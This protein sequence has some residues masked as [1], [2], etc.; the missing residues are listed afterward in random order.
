M[1]EKIIGKVNTYLKTY[2]E[3]LGQCKTMEDIKLFIESHD[4]LNLEDLE[5]NKKK[6]SKNHIKPEEQCQALRANKTQCTRRKKDN[7]AYCGTH[8][9]GTPYGIIE[10]NPLPTCKKTLQVFTQEMQGILYYI[11]NDGNIYNTE[12]IVNRVAKP[13]IVGKYNCTNDVYVRIKD[14]EPI[15]NTE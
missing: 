4:K 3:K 2:N 6:R 12:D 13:R 5:I 14:E 9:K 11:D 10:P 8:T 15:K 7:C 1:E